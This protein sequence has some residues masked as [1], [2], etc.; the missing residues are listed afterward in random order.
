MG[1]HQSH[2]LCHIFFP[3]P[4]KGWRHLEPSPQP[5]VSLLHPKWAAA[6]FPR[7]LVSSQGGRV[8]LQALQVNIP[9]GRQPSEHHRCRQNAVPGGDV[10]RHAGS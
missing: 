7:P 5:Q 3:P 10:C 9:V 6:P 4:K 2:W 1:R 8:M